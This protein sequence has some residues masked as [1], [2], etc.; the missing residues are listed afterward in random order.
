MVLKNAV[1]YEDSCSVFLF[2][3]PTQ[4]ALGC[5]SFANVVAVLMRVMALERVIKG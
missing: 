2:F 1:I 5:Y 3:C 4:A